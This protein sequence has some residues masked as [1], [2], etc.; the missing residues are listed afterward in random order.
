[1]PT[2][3]RHKSSIIGSPLEN[4]IKTF[5]TA[6]AAPSTPD[7][8]DKCRSPGALP[9]MSESVTKHMRRLYDE[10]KGRDEQLSREK[11]ETFLKKTQKDHKFPSW[12]FSTKASHFTFQDFQHFW[13]YDYSAAK[14]PLHME[15]KDLDKPIS[16]YFI[17]SSHNTYIEDGNQLTGEPKALQYAKVLESGCRCVEIDVWDASEESSDASSS[18]KSRSMK[19]QARSHW[20]FSSMFSWMREQ[21]Q[22]TRSMSFSRKSLRSSKSQAS[23]KPKAPHRAR[24][25]SATMLEALKHEPRVCHALATSVGDVTFHRSIPLRTVCQAIR[26][27]AFS[28]GNELPIIISLEVH[29]NLQQQEKMVEIMKEEWRGLLLTEPLPHCDPDTAQPTVR[30]L[31]KKILIKV[32]TAPVCSPSQTNALDLQNTSTTVSSGMLSPASETFYHDKPA[33]PAPKTRIHESL[34]KLAIYTFSPGRFESFDAE[35]AKRPGHIFSFGEEKI[36]ALHQTQHNG[37]FVHNQK[38]L[39]RTYPESLKSFLSSNPNY[40]TLFWRKGVQMV[41]LNWQVWDTAMELNSAM[42]DNENGWVLKPPGYRSSTIVGDASTKRGAAKLQ[43]D[44][45]GKKRLELTITVLAGQHLPTP[46]EP[47]ESTRVD[48]AAVNS[49]DY[50]PRVTCFLHVENAGERDPGKAMSKDEIAR[51]TRPARTEQPDW[52]TT[53]ARLHFPTVRHVIEELSFVR[54]VLLPLRTQP[55]FI[56]HHTILPLLVLYKD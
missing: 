3:G 23:F 40:P 34:Q 47:E 10:L 7:A 14:R 49:V 30:D 20:S 35:D 33:K 28:H 27:N 54:Y 53:G 42:F 18:E 41:A 21:V 15:D 1:M 22:A 55:P 46:Q 8:L 4:A 51:K 9:L 48:M 16:N 12:S 38:F 50:R 24:A 44:L 2:W 45:K 29:A 5:S 13:W 25:L 56:E 11:F 43:A 6:F 19:S 52:G 17:S 39:A 36:K 37:L 26:D 32:K 31:R